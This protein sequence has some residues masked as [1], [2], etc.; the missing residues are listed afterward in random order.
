MVRR[1]TKKVTW[2]DLM[3]KMKGEAS[4]YNK[5]ASFY[6]GDYISHTKFGLGYIQTTFGNKIEVLF[7]DKVRLLVQRVVF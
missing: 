3:K 4:E 6:Q 2:T 5:S 7:E 1:S